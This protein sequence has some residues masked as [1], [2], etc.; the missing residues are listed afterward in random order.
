MAEDSEDNPVVDSD[1]DEDGEAADKNERSLQKSA[2]TES[3]SEILNS[4]MLSPLDDLPQEHAS[5][6]SPM[7]IPSRRPTT[8]AAQ[9]KRKKN[10]N[11]I[12]IE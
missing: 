2:M 12:K 9:G 6:A 10:L 7:R 3:Y 1:N 11:Q 5:R 8:L 4:P